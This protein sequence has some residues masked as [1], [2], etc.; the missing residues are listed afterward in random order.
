[1]GGFAFSRAS[2]VR[3]GLIGC[4]GSLAGAVVTVGDPVDLGPGVGN[5]VG[6]V[7]VSGVIAGVTVAVGVA[8]G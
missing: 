4:T 5:M 8:V 2:G 1:M 7:V 6:V 3:G